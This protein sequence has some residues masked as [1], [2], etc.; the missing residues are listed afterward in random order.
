[1]ASNILTSSIVGLDGHRVDVECD[2]SPG[3]PAFTVVGLPD[4]A[5][6][7]ARERVKGAL[8]QSDLPFPRTHVTINL[9]PADLRKAGTHFDLPIAISV[10][11]AHGDLPK[12]DPLERVLIGELALD[13]SLR[14]VTGALSTALM[15]KQLG[16]KEL[17]VPEGNA[18]EASLVPDVDVRAA[19]TLRDVVLHVTGTQCLLRT[20]HTAHPA[21]THN[22]IHPDLGSVRGQ[23]FARRAIEV[24]SAGGHNILM[25]GPPGSG[26]T[27]LARAFPSILPPLTHDEALDVTRI[28]SIAGK[29]PRD[30]F[31]SERPFRSPHHTASGIALVGGGSV[32]RPGEISLAHRGVLFLDEFP[33]FNRSVLENLRQPLEDGTVT[34]SRANGTVSF[35]ARFILLAAMNPCPCGYRTDPDRPCSCTQHQLHQYRKRISGPMLDRIDISIDV[36]SVPTERLVD[37]E[38]GEPSAAVRTRTCMAR[39]RQVE[40][41]RDIGILTNAELTSDHVRRLIKQNDASRTLLRR[42]VDAYRLSARAYFR[43]LKVSRTIADLDGT[44]GIEERHVA[45]ALKYRQ[46]I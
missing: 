18:A 26:K 45:E 24:A 5:V 7:E 46:P 20:E 25:Q 38:P 22:I 33:E 42:A 35:P 37:L 30:G 8:R 3:L 17:I 28:H 14:P 21:T 13:G 4:T 6:Q 19:A 36:P 39:K 2:I 44:D 15:V 32:P 10:L 40:R 27:L 41:Y 12:R 23:E 43:I 29:L 34:I 11:T 31:V 1:M 16:I 9:A